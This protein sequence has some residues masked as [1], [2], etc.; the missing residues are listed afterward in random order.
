MVNKVYPAELH[1]NKANTSDT[2]AS[3]LNCIC[4]FVVLLFLTTFKINVTILILKLSI[5]HF[6][7]VIFLALRPMEFIFLSTHSIC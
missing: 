1:L 5:S 7:M 6:K 2:E 4:P 3:F